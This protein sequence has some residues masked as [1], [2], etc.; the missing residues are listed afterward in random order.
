MLTDLVFPTI[1]TYVTTIGGFF[2]PIQ[3]NQYLLL[4]EM[5]FCLEMSICP[6]SFPLMVALCE[7]RAGSWN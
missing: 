5:Q 4:M 7:E 6:S 1:P 2:F 3:L